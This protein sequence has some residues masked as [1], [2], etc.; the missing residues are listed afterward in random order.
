[1]APAGPPRA[2][3]ERTRD[4]FRWDPG[5]CYYI[6]DLTTTQ[7][8]REKNRLLHNHDADDRFRHPCSV[9]WRAWKAWS[10]KWRENGYGG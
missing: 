5:Q 3:V 7:I 10:R 2:V 8:R 6:H 4:D 9:L 1:M